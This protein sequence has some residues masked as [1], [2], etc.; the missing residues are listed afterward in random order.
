MLVS[1]ESKNQFAEVGNTYPGYEDVFAKVLVGKEEGWDD[2]TIKI[3]EIQEKGHTDRHSHEYQ[4]IL[5]ALD[6][7]GNA[8][9]DGKDHPLEKGSFVF[10]TPGIE[11]Q[12]TNVGQDV[13]RYI[14]ITTNYE[15][16]ISEHK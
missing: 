14:F 6:G 13:F 5:F 2:Y 4:H 3:F 15:T 10:F 9:I 11:H 7:K 8:Y 12:I 16:F 1:H